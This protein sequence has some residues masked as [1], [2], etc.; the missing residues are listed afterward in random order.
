MEMAK[1]FFNVVMISILLILIALIFRN[2][3]KAFYDAGDESIYSSGTASDRVRSE[4]IEQLA[5]FQDGY[6][7]R[8]T[9]QVES[10]ME[11]L[12]SQENILVL[13]T[14]PDEVFV[15]QKE[16]S[17]LIFSDWNAWGD[18]I[19]LMDKAHI[20][21]SGN[22]A[23][24][25]TIGQVQFDLP[26]FLT[27]PLRLSGVMVKEGLTWKFQSLQFQFDLNF[28]PLFLITLILAI[29]LFVSLVYLIVAL[30]K[31]IRKTQ[32]PD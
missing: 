26:R 14:M 23:W 16:V 7:K 3:H 24:I 4:I 22:V 28:I 9:D 11:Q 32:V 25:S 27:L 5:K 13:G 10:F 15:G 6:I 30:V 19:F 1:R 17:K 21:T 31:S 12:F 2:P 18:C 29:W 20:S 8:D